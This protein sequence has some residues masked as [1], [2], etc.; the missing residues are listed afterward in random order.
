MR[1]RSYIN[2]AVAQASSYSSNSTLSLGTSICHGSSP[3][4]GKKKKLMIRKFCH[5]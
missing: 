1:L 2:V 5:S 3:R 4:N